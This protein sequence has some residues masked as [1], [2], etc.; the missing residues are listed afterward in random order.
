MTSS[1]CS[2]PS[3]TI[4]PSATR[5]G[6]RREPPHEA[7]ALPVR[8]GWS[9]TT[10]ATASILLL[11]WLLAA[12]AVHLTQGTADLGATELWQLAT[13]QGTSQAAS[14]VAESRLPR[15]LA[16]LTV[17]AALGASGATMQA[18]A[19]NPLASPDT[20]AVNAGAFLCLTVVAVLGYTLS[21]LTG[22]AFAFLGGLAAATVVIVLSSGASA[23]PIRLVLAG[24]AITTG[25]ASI[26]AV[27]LL[28]FPW[29]TQNLFAW[30]AGSL[31]QNGATSVRALA[32]IVVVALI[33]VVLLGRR[34][35]L[36]Q[37]GDDA[38]RSLGMNVTGARIGFV[39]LAVVLA[40]TSV[41]IVGPIGFVGLC[42]PVLMRLLAHWV[43]PMRR[44]RVLV[45][46]SAL[47]GV[48]LV[49]TADVALRA[50]FGSV[51]GVTVPT[52][53][54]T[55][56]LGAVVLIVLAQ[57]TRASMSTDT[58]ATM[59][60]A[61]RRGLGAQLVIAGAVLVLAG[62]AM[63]AVLIGDSTLLLG[64]V[65][66][67]FQGVAS[68]HVQIVLETRVPRVL[69]ALLAGASLALAGA[70][71]QA[72]TRNPLAD[73]GILGISGAAGLG[74]VAVIISSTTVGFART[75]GGALLGAAIAAV[76]V[77]L[78]GA[79][80]STDQTRMV[81]VGVGVGA[82]ASALT[83]L[84]IV[85]SD[86]WNQNMAITWLGGSTYGATLLHQAPMLAALAVAVIVVSRTARDLDLVQFDDTTPRTLGI[87]LH[88]TQLLHI[89]I[90][91]LLTAAAT[92][93]IGVIAFV[94]LVAPHAARLMI[95]K[96]HRHMLPLSIT[97]G[98]LLVVIADLVGRA[99]IAPG[100]LPAGM[101][102]AVIGTPYF[103][104]L[105]WRMRPQRG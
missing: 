73:P 78:L 3:L 31:G 43:R 40:T 50:S 56:L 76:I 7:P 46:M 101:V 97:L 71:V 64:D 92:A 5:D 21:P 84:L 47:A 23:S 55:S 65:A 11:L 66:H 95:G 90:A 44:H 67:W 22:A 79:R 36:L 10:M 70:L 91:V 48:A 62:A 63:A 37:L 49:L 42:A 27:L 80:G 81:L 89:S 93:S 99:A 61:T 52:G 85:Q 88:R 18:V 105:L 4:A 6:Q 30:G 26:T 83:T 29:Q 33:A 58:L 20:T 13:G 8:R 51:S 19:R 1:G 68:V 17:G 100:Q 75:L 86:P 60:A 59:H 98:A 14:I 2:G 82:G 34:L 12:V 38:A 15:L 54:I 25:L 16:G 94:G 104:W 74:A 102:T 103:L 77:F 96:R 41:A 39:L 32:P 53:V 72:V 87:D 9:V 69:A 35:D 24:S 57:R 45:V 28:L